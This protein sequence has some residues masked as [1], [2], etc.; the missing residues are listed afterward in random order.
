MVKEF[1]SQR[2]IGFTEYDVSRDPAA[3]QELVRN[4]GQMGVPV[5]VINGQTI[6][7]FDRN[8]LEQALSQQQRPSLGASVAD[9]SKI[10]ARYGTGITLG[11]F[12]GR[13]RPNSLAE[14]LGL[15]AGDVIVELNMQRIPTADDLERAIS[16]LGKGS[17]VSLVFVRGN[18][19]LTAEGTL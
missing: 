11:A 19:E 5:T 8:Q 1:L 6:V 16:R 3:A 9:A 4:T 10:T 15:S 17:R 13:V 18:K 7:G 14:R 2:G 12:V